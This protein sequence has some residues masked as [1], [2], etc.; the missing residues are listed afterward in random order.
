MFTSMRNLVSAV[1]MSLIP[2]R[3]LCLQYIRASRSGKLKHT[4]QSVSFRCLGYTERFVRKITFEQSL[5]LKHRGGSLRLTAVWPPCCQSRCA[6]NSMRPLT[7]GRHLSGRSLP[8]PPFAIGQQLHCG[9]DPHAIHRIGQLSAA[10]EARDIRE[11]SPV[12]A[13][14]GGVWMD[15]IKQVSQ[16]PT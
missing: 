7:R 16:N 10:I 15:A 1:A 13:R 9:Y 14:P 12:P 2:L 6:R 4:D 8:C 5:D 3:R 11:S